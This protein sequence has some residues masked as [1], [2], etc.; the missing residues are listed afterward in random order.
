MSLSEKV[1][2]HLRQ[3]VGGVEFRERMFF[4]FSRS[5][6]NP[7]TILKQKATNN[8]KIYVIENCYTNIRN[9]EKKYLTSIDNIDDLLYFCDTSIV[10]SRFKTLFSLKTLGTHAV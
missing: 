1:L 5:S 8:T 3:N 6:F 9:K 7:D 10:F 4:S 2:F